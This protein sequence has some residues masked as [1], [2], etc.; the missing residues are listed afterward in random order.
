VLGAMSTVV[1]HRAVLRGGLP[2]LGQQL[3]QASSDI[4]LGWATS[5]SHGRSYY[6]RQLRDTK[7]S[8][9]IETMTPKGLWAYG[10]SVRGRSLA[11]TPAPGHP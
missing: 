10:R 5:A 3:M 9:E 2:G 7:S 4:F 6:W 11:P 8:A 1:D